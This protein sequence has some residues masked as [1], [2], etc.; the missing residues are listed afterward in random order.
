MILLYVILVV[1]DFIGQILIGCSGFLETSVGKSGFK[2][3][4]DVSDTLIQLGFPV[5]LF[6]LIT[7]CLNFNL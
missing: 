1:S 7:M 6:A 4:Y 3:A 5:H 2:R